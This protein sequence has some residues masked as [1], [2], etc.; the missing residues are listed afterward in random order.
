M[1]G[2][3]VKNSSDCKMLFEL[4][5]LNLLQGATTKKL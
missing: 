5:K 2:S 4:L 3:Y 1:V